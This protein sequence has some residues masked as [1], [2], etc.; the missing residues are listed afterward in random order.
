[1]PV[2][3]YTSNSKYFGIIVPKEVMKLLGFCESNEIK[4]N[5]SNG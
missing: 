2:L 5:D 4:R 1:M 3:A